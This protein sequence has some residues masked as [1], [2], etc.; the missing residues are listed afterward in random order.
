MFSALFTHTHFENLRSGSLASTRTLENRS[1][2]SQNHASTWSR[3]IDCTSFTTVFLCYEV[4][5]PKI[6]DIRAL[7]GYYSIVF[8]DTLSIL[9]EIENRLAEQSNFQ[10][11]TNPLL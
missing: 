10:I 6:C 2:D 4:L 8:D 7:S 1:R 11:W 5:A 9:N 3:W